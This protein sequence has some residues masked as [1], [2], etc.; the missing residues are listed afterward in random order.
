V[1]L[2]AI[3]G[4]PLPVYG[5]GSNIRDWLHVEDH[6]RALRLVVDSGVPG[7]TYCVGGNSERTNLA[8]VHAICDELDAARPR[9]DGES[10]RSQITYVKDR[11]GHDFRYAID[12]A[13]IG[14]ELGWSPQESFESGI[15]GTVRWYLD[16]EAWWSAI[17]DGSYRGERLGLPSEDAANG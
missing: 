14:R 13:K 7:E 8:V 6:A 5:D 9:A 4:Q 2:K 17:H 15:A 12:T 1:I 3:S 16:N 11:P 10:Y